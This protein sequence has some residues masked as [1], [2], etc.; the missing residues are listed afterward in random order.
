MAN[1]ELYE[2]QITNVISKQRRDVFVVSSDNIAFKK[3][4]ESFLV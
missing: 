4:F 2:V 1:V 3:A